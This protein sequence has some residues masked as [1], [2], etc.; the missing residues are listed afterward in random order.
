MGTPFSSMEA[1]YRVQGVQASPSGALETDTPTRSGPKR[2]GGELQFAEAHG[3]S[4][5]TAIVYTDNGVKPIAELTSGT[6][7][8]VLAST[9]E[10]G[11]NRAET[12]GPRRFLPGPNTKTE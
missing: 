1:L 11:K 9:S 7:Y 12:P 3:L 5:N 4:V 8:Y 2:S 6:T 10:D